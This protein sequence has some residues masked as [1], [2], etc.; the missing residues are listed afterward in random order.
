MHIPVATPF[1]VL[2]P[3]LWYVYSVFYLSISSP[4]GIMRY[5][6][7][8]DPNF[9]PSYENT[10]EPYLHTAPLHLHVIL[11]HFYERSSLPL[12]RTCLSRPLQ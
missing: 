3:L 6:G 10:G 2:L 7:T 8:V 4:Y 1:I 11:L 12:P 5:Q 9:V